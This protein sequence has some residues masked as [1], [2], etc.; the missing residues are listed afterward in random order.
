MKISDIEVGTEYYAK[1]GWSTYN[2]IVV[3]KGE[4]EVVAKTYGFPFTGDVISYEPINI[5]CKVP[6]KPPQTEPKSWFE[7]FFGSSK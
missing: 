2:I 7:L 5:I 6:P 3:A 4:T 1:F